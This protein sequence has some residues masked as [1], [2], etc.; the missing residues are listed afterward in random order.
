MLESI[1]GFFVLGS[2]HFVDIIKVFSLGLESRK[3]DADLKEAVT[4]LG[5]KCWELNLLSPESHPVLKEIQKYEASIAEKK[6]SLENIVQEVTEL[7][8]SRKQHLAHYESKL[9]EQLQLKRPVDEE[10]TNLLVE[11]KRMKKEHA[12]VRFEIDN[13]GKKIQVQKEHL[14]KFQ[15]SGQESNRY[16]ASELSSE[17]KL[18]E[19][20]LAIDTEKSGF[21]SANIEEGGKQADNIRKVVQQFENQIADLRTSERAVLDNIGQ[22]IKKLMERKHG[23]EKQL[24]KI[25]HELRPILNALGRQVVNK[26]IE[27]GLLNEKFKRID[28]LESENDRVQQEI[29][30]LQSEINSISVPI[31]VGFYGLAIGIIVIIAGLII[32]IR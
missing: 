27:S 23:V 11:I 28:D 8:E 24:S 29:T 17:I 4:T 22:N 6:Y 10:L 21:L 1:K 13:L 26:R 7:R 20:T 5:R 14:E 31:K 30:Q 18:N 12:E 2:R 32:F 16:L 3:I 15:K 19:R 9:T 25:K